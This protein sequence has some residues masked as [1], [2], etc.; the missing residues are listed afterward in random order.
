MYTILKRRFYVSINWQRKFEYDVDCSRKSIC[1]QVYGSLVVGCYK[2]LLV[3][4]YKIYKTHF[5]DYLFMVVGLE[6]RGVFPILVFILN[7]NQKSSKQN[8]ILQIVTQRHHHHRRSALRENP[9]HPN[10]AAAVHLQHPIYPLK[11]RNQKIMKIASKRK[12]VINM[13][14]HPHRGQ[15]NV[16]EI[17]L[18]AMKSHSSILSLP[19]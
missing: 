18:I 9:S 1:R 19:T 15:V 12:S 2:L 14:K 4:L 11:R 7:R 10:A 16:V 8:P 13:A 6:I 5:I 17:V 3:A